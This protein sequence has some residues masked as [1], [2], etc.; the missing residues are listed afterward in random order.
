MKVSACLELLF[1]TEAPDLPGRIRLAKAAGFDLVEFWRWT[2]KDLDATEAAL[3]ETGVKV[4]GIV[5]EPMIALTDPQNHA[6]FL[7]EL[8]RSLAVAQRLGAPVM[9][10]QAGDEIAGMSRDAQRAALTECLAKAADVIAGSGVVIV[11][12]PLN[13]LVDHA[14][15]YLSS[16]VEGLD[17]VDDVGRSDIRLLYDIYHSAVMGEE[18][19]DVLAGRVDRVAHVHLADHPS[20][21]EPGSGQMD[22]QRRLDWIVGAGYRGPIGLEFKPTGSTVES[23]RVF[24]KAV[25]RRG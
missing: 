21:N 7:S 12:E 14:G 8:P 9:I 24:D 6:R 20:R 16:T 2:N 25:G 1:K 3:R 5:A 23:L 18:I 4:A 19:S 13:T 15:Y 17:I 22:W 10:A 11:L